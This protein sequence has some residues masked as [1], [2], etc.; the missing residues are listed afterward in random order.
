M[1]NV[2]A[3]TIPPDPIT[4]VTSKD[5]ILFHLGALRYERIELRVCQPYLRATRVKFS[6][7]ARTRVVSSH[8]H[9][10]YIF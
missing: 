4:H 7:L 6:R 2:N 3:I 8:S 10:T 9:S 5:I 1:A